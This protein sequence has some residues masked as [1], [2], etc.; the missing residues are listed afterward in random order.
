[1]NFRNFL[2]VTIF[3]LLFVQCKQPSE[4]EHRPNVILVIVDDMGFSDLGAYG[5]EIETPNIDRLAFEGVRFTNAYNT[6]KCYPSRA[7]ILTGLYSQQTGYHKSFRQEMQNAI[8]LGELFKTAGYTTLW[9]GK[10]HSIENPVTRGFD[11]YSGLLDGA[12][13][14]FNPGLRRPGEGQPAQKGLKNSP[15]TY[16]NWVIDGEVFNPYTPESKDFYTTDVFTDYALKWINAV[17]DQNP[18]FLYL[19]YTAPHDPLMARPEDIEKYQNRYDLG[20]QKIRE[21]RFEKQKKLG[22]LPENTVLSR[23]A[24]KNWGDLNENEKADEQRTMAVYAAMIDRLDQNVGRILDTLESQGKLENTL[25]VFTS[26]NGGSS[27]VVNLGDGTGEIGTMTNWKSLGKNW[28]NVS[29]TPYREYKNWSHEGGIKTPLIAYWPKGIKNKNNIAHTPV[30][31][32]DVLPTFQELLDVEYPEKFNGEKIISSPGR[33]FLPEIKGEK[34]RNRSTPIFWQWSKG[35]AIRQEDWK[36]VSYNNEWELYN[37]KDD[38]VEEKN[39]IE[40]NPEKAEF[41]KKQYTE[42]AKQFDLE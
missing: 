23:A 29:N 22:V 41:L 6:S 5:S 39:L 27:E 24:H 11:H 30:H 13:N 31:F 2:F 37:L 1:V 19:A 25:I 42:W 14:H 32:I 17:D 35:K 18:F 15:I 7:C 34:Y 12:S 40:D 28:A 8:T 3:S 16:R 36:L 10:H 33:S 21:D 4:I 38:P 20:Y 9:S 26:D